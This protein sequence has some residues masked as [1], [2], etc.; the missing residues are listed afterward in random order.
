MQ[1]P[2]QFLHHSRGRAPPCAVRA[3]VGGR[4]D[5]Q[6]ACDQ[7]VVLFPPVVSDH[8]VSRQQL[9][10]R[11]ENHAVAVRDVAR[12]PQGSRLGRARHAER[13]SR[14]LAGQ[15]ASGFEVQRAVRRPRI[16]HRELL[17]RNNKTQNLGRGDV[18][19]DV[20]YAESQGIGITY[21]YL[22]DPRHQTAA[23]MERQ[24]VAIARHPLMP[25]PTYMSVIAPL[26]GTE[27]FWEDLK[28]GR[29]APN[30]R[31]RDLTAK[32]SPTPGLRTTRPRCQF[33]RAPVPRAL[34]RR[35]ARRHRDQDAATH[36]QVGHAQ[37]G[38][39]VLRGFGEPA[40]LR[41]V[42][43]GDCAARTYIA[44][45]EILDPQYREH[46][47]DLSEEDRERY[48]TPIA[49]TD[50]SGGPAD[51]LKPYFDRRFSARKREEL[52]DLSAGQG[53]GLSRSIAGSDH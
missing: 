13:H 49:L 1:L 30:L 51:W 23:E 34:A 32:R 33:H 17:R 45:S 12:Q 20:A 53:S 42:A 8:P 35:R 18:I 9:L 46:P 37:S 4:G 52:H 25:M 7:P 38:A 28:S 26:A 47:S 16:A 11:R 19:E 44:G 5:R 43:R 41:L 50:A 22:F 15:D 40:L 29:L 10:R 31:F 39:L 2:L 14:P 48:F 27:T 3:E 24:I 21:G 6:R 36:R